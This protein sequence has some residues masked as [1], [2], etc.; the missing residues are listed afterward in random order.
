MSALS[1]TTGSPR[2][3]SATTP[4]L[5]KVRCGMPSSSSVALQGAGPGGG[6]LRTVQVRRGTQAGLCRAACLVRCAT[7][8]RAAPGTGCWGTLLLMGGCGR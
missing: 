4:V 3:S 1:A 2:P 5:A 7:A 8:G 6:P